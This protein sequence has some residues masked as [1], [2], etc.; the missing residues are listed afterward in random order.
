MCVAAARS[1][2]V[3]LCE[4]RRERSADTEAADVSNLTEFPL[5]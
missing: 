2:C 4:R 5:G 3:C 1:V